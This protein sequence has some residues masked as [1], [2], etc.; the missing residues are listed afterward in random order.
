MKKIN[1][2]TDYIGKWNESDWS[3]RTTDYKKGEFTD[4]RFATKRLA[5]RAYIA[6]AQ[7]A[8]KL[9][10]VNILHSGEDKTDEVERWLSD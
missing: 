8:S 9:F 1:T 5:V 7:R 3:V 10:G 4:R 6:F 2:T